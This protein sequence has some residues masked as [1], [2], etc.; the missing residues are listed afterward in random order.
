MTPINS[1][2]TPSS[3]RLEIKQKQGRGDRWAGPEARGDCM[4]RD[5]GLGWREDGRLWREDQQGQVFGSSPG[6]SF[7]ASQSLLPPSPDCS[8]SPQTP[9]GPDEC[10]CS[11]VQTFL[12]DAFFFL[13]QARASGFRGLCLSVG[14][15]QP[16]GFPLQLSPL[17]PFKVVTE[18]R[19][20]V[21][22]TH[23]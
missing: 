16:M 2:G 12:K 10:L 14:F 8:L 7:L 4:M 20:L 3:S 5:G 13:Q 6:H 1:P 19:G 11:G 15:S 21:T 9:P 18:G 22:H 17:W 23:P